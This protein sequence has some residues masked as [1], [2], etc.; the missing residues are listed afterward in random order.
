MRLDLQPVATVSTN[1][2]EAGDS[3]CN[4]GKVKAFN[5][6]EEEKVVLWSW[7]GSGGVRRQDWNKEARST[8]CQV[9]PVAGLMCG[10][11]EANT[12]SSGHFIWKL[13]TP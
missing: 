5:V 13:Q 8:P 6:A 7:E 1:I 9:T 12:R 11:D 10:I 4:P 3:N 2:C